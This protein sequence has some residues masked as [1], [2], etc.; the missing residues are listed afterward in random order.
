[1]IPETD[2]QPMTTWRFV[3][4]LNEGRKH[5]LSEKCVEHPAIHREIVTKY[6]S[7]GAPVPNSARTFYF[8][9]EPYDKTEYGNFEDALSALQ[10]TKVS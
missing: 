1:M 2:A 5:I 8:V 10:K 9:D 7:Y 4:H 6:N 3:G